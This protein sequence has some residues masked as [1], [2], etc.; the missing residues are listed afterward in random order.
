MSE[1]NE[2]FLRITLIWADSWSVKNSSMAM[3]SKC[4]FTDRIQP[5]QF[6]QH[7]QLIYFLNNEHAVVGWVRFWSSVKYCWWM[8]IEKKKKKPIN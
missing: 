2:M 7:V 1:R 8:E 4:S 6:P 3:Y 5:L